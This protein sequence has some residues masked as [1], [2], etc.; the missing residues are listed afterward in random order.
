MSGCTT[1]ER[2]NLSTGILESA[3]FATTRLSSRYPRDSLA[4][5]SVGARPGLGAVRLAVEGCADVG[6]GAGYGGDVNRDAQ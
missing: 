2:I 5:H 1:A 3:F 4:T 6:E